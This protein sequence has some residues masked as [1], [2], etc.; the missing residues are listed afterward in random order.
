ML[1]RRR[2]FGGEPPFYPVG[3]A[4]SCRFDSARSCKLTKTPAGAGNRKTFQIDVLVKRCSLGAQNTIFF[5]DGASS[6]DYLE[7][8]SGDALTLVLGGTTIR[9][10][11]AL[12]RDPSQHMHICLMVDTTR[13]AASDR[14]KIY[15]NG[16]LV[17]AFS[18]TAD[19]AQNSEY[20]INTAVPHTIGL[21][22]ATYANFYISRFILVD[23]STPGPFVRASPINPNVYVPNT[24]S[25]TYG[26]NG[27]HLDF[28][29][30]ADLGNDVSGNNNDYTSSGLTSADQMADTPTNNYCTL[31]PLPRATLGSQLSN[32]N[33]DS[34]TSGAAGVSSN[35]G[36][37]GMSTGAFYA[38]VTVVTA[39]SISQA[40]TVGIFPTGTATRDSGPGYITNS[41]GYDGSTGNKFISNVGSA[42]GATYTVGDIIGIAFDADNGTLEFFKN[43]VSQ[44]TITGVP[45]G[46]YVFAGCEFTSSATPYKI[47][48]NFGA[49]PFTYAQPTGFKA[50]CSESIVDPLPAIT[51][52]GTFTGNANADG[53]FVYTG[54]VL[55]S[56][57]I[58]GNAVTF[59][60]HADK[61]ANGFKV[62]T[63][64]A[65][66]NDAAP[67][68]WTAT[69]TTDMRFPRNNAQTNP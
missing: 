13:A 12:F 63:A 10:T 52:S 6:D 31:N 45:A 69:A 7:F 64:A 55:T 49:T 4:H 56:L 1:G 50:L 37:M 59:G 38:E 8:T 9:T 20:N 17:T 61:V 58:D 24:V 23:G 27:F 29:N 15:V 43:G 51:T 33:L 65:G 42:Y 53:P 46:G 22:G 18:A 19:P 44:G 57:T 36:T 67:N 25:A 28:A 16:S 11:T 60:T 2:L 48:F 21:R 32:G 5:A 30:A 35:F 66:Y 3:I 26:T 68:N 14:V 40:I 47:R 39:E 54:G 34:T 62:R 41:Y